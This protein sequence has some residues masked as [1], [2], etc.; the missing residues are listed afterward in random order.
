MKALALM[1]AAL[2]G[3]GGGGGE[4][5]INYQELSTH[6]HTVT[7][8]FPFPLEAVHLLSL[9]NLW[10]VFMKAFPNSSPCF[11]S[12]FNSMSSAACFSLEGTKQSLKFL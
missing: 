2:G 10:R 1:A 8:L 11:G 12:F 6:T 7:H 3:G 9:L 4:K 5:H